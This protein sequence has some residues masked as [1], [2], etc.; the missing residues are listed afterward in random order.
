LIH[1]IL[2]GERDDAGKFRNKFQRAFGAKVIA[3]SAGDG[4]W[5][6]W[7]I[8]L[9]QWRFLGRRPSWFLDG[10]RGERGGRQQKSWKRGEKIAAELVCG[11][12]NLIPHFILL[13]KM[14]ARKRIGLS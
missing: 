2:P 11:F 13:E 14:F 4:E 3:P 6:Y 1:G 7:N 12:H 8:T 5:K 9:G 10:L